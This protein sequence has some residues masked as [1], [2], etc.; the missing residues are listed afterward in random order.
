MTVEIKSNKTNISCPD[1]KNDVNFIHDYERGEI[2]CENCGIVI[3]EKI[4]DQGPEWRA[5]NNSEKEKRSRTGSPISY[6][7]HDKG[8]STVI[9]RHNI[10]IHGKK[11]SGK[12]CQKFYRIRKWH[13]RSLIIDST[14]RNLSTAMT[15]LDRLTSQLDITKGVKESAAI[16]YHKALDRNIIRGRSINTMITATLYIACKLRKVPVTLDDILKY[17]QINKKKLG[18][19][20]RLLIQGLGIKIPILN[21]KDFISRICADLELSNQVQKKACEIINLANN[22]NITTG[23]EP[24][25]LAAAAIYIAGILED[26]RITQMKLAKMTHISEVTIRSRCKDLKTK[27]KIN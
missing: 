7:I 26:E 27:L 17:T 21:A 19:A 20:Y 11:L 23:K 22:Q 3:S 4:I 1:C 10:D 24:M 12:T 25:G 6:T 15:E 2:I 9:D 18:R 16:I 13:R 8:L 14:A 5:F